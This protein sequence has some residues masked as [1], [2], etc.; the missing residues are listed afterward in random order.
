M[1]KR[2]FILALFVASAAAP[3]L[4]AQASTLP[5]AQTGD[6]TGAATD[7]GRKLVD[8]AIAAL[9]GDKW[10]NRTNW[11]QVGQ[12]T[13]FYKSAPNPYVSGFEEYIRAQP[14]GRRVVVVSETP[15]ILPQLILGT[16]SVSHSKDVSLVYTPD[17]AF[18][19]TFRGKKELPKDELEDYRRSQKYRLDVILRDWANRPG[20]IISYEGTEM[21]ERRLADRVSILT[22]DNQTAILE[23]QE[24]THLPLSRTVIYRDPLYKDQDTDVEQ[25]DN[26]QPFDG[27]ETP[28]TITRLHNGDM[29]AQRFITKIQYNLQLSDDVFDPDRPLGKKIKK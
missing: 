13:T 23:L 20:T 12:T 22:P 26:Y 27:I 14:Y 6:K 3:Q 9:G 4:H 1:Q 7:R 2:L 21:V 8:E 19:V 10:L 17:D 28:M 18:E 25:Y 24:G 29:V 5:S 15:R 11:L 16:P